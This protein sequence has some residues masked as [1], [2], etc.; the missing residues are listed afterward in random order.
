M[1][2]RAGAAF[3]AAG[4]LTDDKVR[5]QLRDFIVGFAAFAGGAAD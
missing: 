3:D 1:V 4:D 5:E 2:S